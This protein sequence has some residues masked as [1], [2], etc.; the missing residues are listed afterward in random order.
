MVIICYGMIKSASTFTFQVVQELA[1]KH[2]ANSG[3]RYVSLPDLDSR[4]KFGFVDAKT[5]FKLLLSVLENTA[6]DVFGEQH[7]AIKTHAPPVHFNEILSKEGV[8]VVAN[9]RHP[10]DI[11]LSLV[12]A[13]KRDK[14]RGR[15]RFDS[16][17]TLEKAAN[18]L[19][20]QCQSFMQ[21][22][23]LGDVFN[24]Y[25]DD[26]VSEPLNTFRELTSYLNIEQDPREILHYFLNSRNRIVECNK[27]LIGRRHG[28]L[29]AEEIKLIEEKFPSILTVINNRKD[30]VFGEC[31]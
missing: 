7:I 9:Y 31:L 17:N 8:R 26:V 25:Y 18:Q 21:W 24:I 30:T 10:A 3:L 28:E 4:F 23:Q 11:V 19:P 1:K 16:Y 27:G 15:S 20:Y 22:K 29:P 5:D 13:A 2:C 12:D 14:A 6:L